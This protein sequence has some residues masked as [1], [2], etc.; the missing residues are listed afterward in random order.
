MASRA[1]LD[2]RVNTLKA[3]RE[4]VLASTAHLET[5]PTPWSPIGLRIELGADARNPGI[6]SEVAVPLIVHDRVVGVMDL[7]CEKVAFFTDEEETEKFIVSAVRRRASCPERPGRPA[8]WPAFA[9]GTAP[10][11]GGSGRCRSR[12]RRR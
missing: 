3:K 8:P 1:P 9:G 4:K 10:R 2:L 6:H 5:K 7:E 12:G 11:R